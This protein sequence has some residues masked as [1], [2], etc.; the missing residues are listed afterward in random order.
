[1]GFSAVFFCTLQP[2]FANCAICTPKKHRKN[3][4]ISRKKPRAGDADNKLGEY[5]VFKENKININIKKVY[6]FNHV[7]N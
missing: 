1:M 6:K 2:S 3:K 4:T 7:I 5:V